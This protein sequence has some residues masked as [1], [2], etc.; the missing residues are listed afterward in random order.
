MI[1]VMDVDDRVTSWV[2]AA[3]LSASTSPPW[4]NICANSSKPYSSTPVWFFCSQNER[5]F[6]TVD[7]VRRWLLFFQQLPL[8]TSQ[9]GIVFPAPHDSPTAPRSD[10]GCMIFVRIIISAAEQPF[11]TDVNHTRLTISGCSAAEQLTQR[12]MYMLTLRLRGVAVCWQYGD[13]WQTIDERLFYLLLLLIKMT[14][15]LQQKTLQ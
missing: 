6:R 7:G 12:K 4:R 10:P 14:D 1:V 15:C 3:V 11:S 5:W 2:T 9:T 13:S 8:R